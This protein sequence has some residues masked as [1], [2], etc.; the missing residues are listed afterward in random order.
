M[1]ILSYF[2]NKSI[3]FKLLFYFFVIIILCIS[4]LTLLGSS[5][6]KSSL[7]DE[8]N[9]YTNQM[10]KQVWNHIEVLLTENDNIIHYLSR[11]EE[12][13]RFLNEENPSA[14]LLEKINRQIEVYK[15]R[16]SEMAGVLIVNEHNQFA[17]NEMF[18]VSRDSLTKEYW[19]QQAV[20]S[21]EKLQ[22]ISNPVGRNIR[23]KSNYQVNNLL[24]VVKAIKDPKTDEVKGVILIDLKLDFIKN[25][26]QSI[27]LGES[28]FI[29]ILN[30]DGN[31]V[32]SPV[33]T[34]VYR[35]NPD[36]FLKSN[37]H[38]I[39]KVIDHNKYHIIYNTYPSI[40]WKVVGVFSLDETTAVV[41]K[42]QLY[43]V[44]I[45]I[46]TLLLAAAVSWFFTR[47]IIN[48]VN[49]LRKL[50]K[51]VEEG[52]FDLQFN[53]KYNDE[54]GQLGRSY[55]RMIQEVS[56]LI[57]LVY[58]EQK[59]KR[60]AEL[61]ILQAQIKPH[62]LYNTLDTI[63]WMAYEYKANRIADMIKALT[64][65]FRI[66]LNKGDEVITVSEEIQH[67]DSYLIIQ[68]TRYESK[69]EYEINV[70]EQV[71]NYKIVKLLLQPL[72]ENAIY[73]GIRNKRGKGKILINVFQKNDTLFLSVK[74][75]GI[76]IPE[77]QVKEMNGFLSDNDL[78]DQQ[79]GYGLFNVNERIKLVYGSQ[80]GLS[81]E[82]LYQ[83]WTFITI[84]LPVSA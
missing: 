58:T 69:L 11:E 63:Q 45:A 43:T 21:P 57:Q 47:S 1:N 23:E 61:K 30:K 41:S 65:L 13:Q 77:D 25:V 16:H 56:R 7:Q 50:M 78:T 12:I 79:H 59:N 54:I 4:T 31:V 46:L 29:F 82:S 18:P 44:F 34:I 74:D 24:S 19:Y 52:R 51:N 80:Y 32:Y 84:H 17:S 62:F 3:G 8:A 75:T 27:K 49:K 55:N 67:V 20:Q 15:G 81:I 10:M 66:G 72:V 36:W 22:L 71:K 73:H 38:S 76:G 14:A 26:I 5:I 70:E 35:I 42:V 2:N 9:S 40:N 83:E 53:S 64:T 28:G 68:M 6:Y 37:T 33:N 60:E 48:P 39:N